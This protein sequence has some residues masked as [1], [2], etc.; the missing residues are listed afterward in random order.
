MDEEGRLKTRKTEGVHGL[1][2]RSMKKVTERYHGVL[3][4]E[5]E[6]DL[7]TLK[8]ILYEPKKA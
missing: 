6:D 8:A 2:I 4:T 1:G 5:G 3:I 7:F